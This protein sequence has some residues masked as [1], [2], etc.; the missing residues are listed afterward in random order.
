MHVF[1]TKH[2][3]N[4][5]PILS[6]DRFLTIQKGEWNERTSKMHHLGCVAL[7]CLWARV[8]F[9]GGL[10]VEKEEL[11]I[12]LVWEGSRETKPGG[13]EFLGS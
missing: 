8:G 12:G 5:F 1:F 7:R 13:R 10:L 2:K 6:L 3:K 11:Q 4:F 9:V